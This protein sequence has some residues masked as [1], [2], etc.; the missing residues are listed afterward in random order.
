MSDFQ[1][2]DTGMRSCLKAVLGESQVSQLGLSAVTT[3]QW[4]CVS[5][6]VHAVQFRSSEVVETKE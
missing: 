6:E 3:V 2:N 5:L 4:S 1:K